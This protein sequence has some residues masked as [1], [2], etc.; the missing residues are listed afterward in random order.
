MERNPFYNGPVSDHFDG[1]R[2]HSP[3]EPPANSLL[4]IAW[5]NAVKATNFWP[6]M[7][8]LARVD[9]PPSRFDG[10]RIVMIGH[11]S[12]LV[13][14]GGQNLLIDPVYADR[15]GPVPGTGPRRA[16]P[17]GVPF[18]DL[19]PIDAIL[20]THNHYDH[21]D[22][23]A[24]VRLARRW[25]PRIIAPLGNDVV[26]RRADPAISVE[27]YDWGE[28]ALLTERLAVHLEPSFHWSGRGVADRRMTL[29][30]SFVIVGTGGGVLYHVGDT[31]YGDGSI[32]PKIA[33]RY[34]PPDV[35]ILPI[36]A[37]EPR[38]FMQA[39]HVDPAEAVQIM[40]DCRAQRAFGHHWGTF[41]MTVEAQEAPPLELARVLEE[42]GIPQDR[43]EALSPGTAVE[44]PWP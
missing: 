41:Q 3:Y 2:F 29:W 1:L 4:E 26:I 33:E 8:P 31:G 27:T 15:L 44:L 20:L 43:F 6:P 38:R 23:P 18:D 13:Q 9:R 40:L 10:L 37:Y 25:E 42:R 39:Q 34:S 14:V 12:L 32:F 11:A 22:L 7:P 19:P 30:C 16:Q 21:M 5:M 36:G 28:R 17:P 35:A 24:I